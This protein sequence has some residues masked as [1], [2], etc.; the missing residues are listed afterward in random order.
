MALIQGAGF[1]PQ[2]VPGLVGFCAGKTIELAAHQVAQGVA[3]E[4]VKTQQNNVGEQHQRAQ[5]NAEVAVPPEGDNCIFPQETQEDHGKIKEIAVE[6]LQDEWE[7]RLAAV[8]MARLAH[9]TGRWIKEEGPVIRFPVVIARHAETQRKRQ[10]QQRRR[11]RPHPAG[12]DQWRIKGR[13]IGQVQGSAIEIPA[14]ECAQS[15]INAEAAEKY[16]GW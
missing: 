15:C 13:K 5:A 4:Q 3:R 12:I 14:F 7:L 8:F 10:D 9:G 16:D 11:I 1:L 6:I 2:A